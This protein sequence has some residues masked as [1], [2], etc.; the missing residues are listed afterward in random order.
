MP[1]PQSL[2]DLIAK[3]AVEYADQIKA[4]A[5]IA[6]K[7]EEIR[8]ESE[9]QLAFI[10]KAAGIKLEGKHEF[11][12]A[13]GRV[14][15]VYSRV[16]IEYKN[17]KSPGDRI[18]PKADSPGSRK[19]VDQIKKRFFDM[20][21][22]HGQPLNSLFGVGL[23]GN[24]FIFV[25]FRDEKWDIQEPVEVNHV[26]AA[27]F[28]WALFNLGSKG[29]AFTPEY[30]AGDFGSEGGNTIAI[31]GI[32]AL[33]D[34]IVT[35]ENP[36]AQT[37][38][39]QW[40]IL[41]GE[42]CG[43]DVDSPSDKIEKLAEFY[44]VG[45]E[46]PK[47][48]E[49]LFAVHTYYALFMKLLAVQIMTK[50]HR[51]PSA[52]EKMMTATTSTRLKREMEDLEAGGIFRRL[53]ITNFL[54][55]D[56]F[57]WY[58]SV[59]TEPIEHLVREM[60]TR[61]DDYN[62]GTLSE[63]PTG[64][65]DLLK[66]LYQQLFPKSVRHD[67]GE[68]YTPDW[69]AEHVLNELDYVGD[70]DKRLLD[71]ACGSGTFLI[72]AINRVR[73][74]HDENRESCR[75]GE[76][77]LGSKILANVVGFDLNP[78][79]VMAARTNYLISIR[80]LIS[81]MDKV[82]I[83]VYL[84][85]SVVTPTE[86]GD[87]FTGTAKAARV[88]CAACTPPHL[89]VPKEIATSAGDV[90]TYANLIEHSLTVEN[91]PE[92]FVDDCV[93]ASLPISDHALHRTLY[94]QLLSLQKEHKNG[95]W[96][97]IIKNA[98]APLFAGRFDFVAGN[99][100]WVNWEHL[101]PEYRTLSEH[102]W[103]QYRL[104]GP[105]PLKKRQQS[106]TSKTDVSILMTYVS[107]DKYLNPEGRLG[108]VITR[109]VFQAEL[110]GWHFRAFK[111]PSQVPL[112]VTCVHDW[113]SIKPFRGQ[114]AN[115]TCT[116]FFKRGDKTVY[117]VSW[118]TYRQVNGTPISEDSQWNEVDQMT[119]KR[120][121]IAYPITSAQP[122]SPWIFGERQAI[123]ILFKVLGPSFYAGRAREG[124]N[125]R[126]ANGIFFLDARRTDGRLLV[127]NRPQDGDDKNLEVREQTIEP[128][129][130]YPLLRGK[131]VSRW[132]AEPSGYV[133]VPHDPTNP[134]NPVPFRELPD[135]TQEFLAFFRD[136]LKAR[137][138]F[139]NFDPTSRDWHGLYS[140]LSA[141]Y[142]PFKV[143][144]REMA[145]G[146]I[147]A[148][149]GTAR[150]PT[151]EQKTVVPDHKLFVIPCESSEEADFVCG[152]FNSAIASYIIL[153]Y[154]IAT[155]ISTHVLERIPI[156]RFDVENKLHQAVVQ[157][158]EACS[159]AVQNGSDMTKTT[160]VLD[161]AVCSALGLGA[162]D[163]QSILDALSNLRREEKV[164]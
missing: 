72:A 60:V 147:A 131:D 89:L 113:N 110:G 95:V 92:Q 56:L 15:S 81:H 93:E 67:L 50:F 154:A 156:P 36:K 24:Y 16:I 97:R 27:R 140:V 21:H 87:L 112:K 144:W 119:S 138:K 125:T 35:T 22:D 65:R 99:P 123:D 74:W 51:L 39:S 79:A 158:T 5:Q 151:G 10:Q 130:V 159:Q 136:R 162:K 135:R 108:F 163:H 82:E 46:N 107:A 42:V 121:W 41:F 1:Q 37:F 111:L 133:L 31:D 128:D 90:A 77:E 118:V 164:G 104:S 13:S 153:S 143:I 55:G 84:C 54:E 69:L 12:V 137:K 148:V 34:A 150:L 62:P 117:P 26:S 122:Q 11:T 149:V 57:A 32:H 14:D 124:I 157:A 64:S 145:T 101:P 30:L 96:A 103:K 160:T 38:F 6:D 58:T 106:D 132:L 129:Y 120:T 59:W 80:D 91:S 19:V 49:L 68:Y 3:E 47:P 18:G 85:D 9:K 33:Y 43:Y 61:L 2:D 109:T 23:D 7:E 155:G 44:K 126:G 88:P 71:P 48:A 29:K 146:S 105:V 142:M 94:A 139:R 28:L 63:D 76:G 115:T 17:P 141:S 52:I 78:L 4:A 98:F 8:I 40:K 127:K 53:N 86:Y 102:I 75:F 161:A 83:P 134:N 66:K 116:A 100:P 152:V 114:A 45:A 25:R 70:P 20:R 73:K